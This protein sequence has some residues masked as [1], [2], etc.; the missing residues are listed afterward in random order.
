MALFMC[1]KLSSYLLQTSLILSLALSLTDRRGRTC[2]VY[3]S[4]AGRLGTLKYNSFRW[5]SIIL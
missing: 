5:Q 4:G 3:H 1:G 2:V